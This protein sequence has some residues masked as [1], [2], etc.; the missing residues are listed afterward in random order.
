M[1]QFRIMLERLE[2][3]REENRLRAIAIAEQEARR[4]Q[5]EEEEQR[6]QQQLREQRERDQRQQEEAQ[7]QQHE[8]RILH[9]EE[10]AAAED[11]GTRL[12]REAAKEWA[13]F[14]AGQRAK[15]ELRETARR[16]RMLWEAESD[17]W[18][19]IRE[20]YLDGHLPILHEIRAAQAAEQDRQRK[21]TDRF[22]P[23]L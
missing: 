21:A 10:R 14:W 17:E 16:V 6:Q 15:V 7:R 22:K 23:L 8:A 20:A 1:E 13:R 11:M 9:Q 18:M 19:E 3:E 2:Q 4:R 5:R 12:Y